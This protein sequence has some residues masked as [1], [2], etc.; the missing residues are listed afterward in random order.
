MPLR[1][2]P[3]PHSRPQDYAHVLDE[4]RAPI[5]IAHADLW[6][7]L[8]PVL[9]QR[10]HLKRVIQCGEIRGGHL[11]WEELL[12]RESP[13]LEASPTQS[14]DVAFW[15]W[16]SGS[17]GAAKAAVHRHQ[18]WG[19]CCERYAR[20]IL[21]IGPLDR[22]FSSS[23]LFHAY[24]LGHGLAFPFYV[25]AATV[26]FPGR[27]LPDSILQT[28]HETPPSL[29]FSVPTLFA[30]M[31]QETDQANPFDLSSVR[32]AI[33]AA[34]PLPAAI[35]QRWQNRFGMELLDG[36][37]STEVLHIYISSRAGEVRA[38]STGKSIPGYQVRITDEDGDEAP[39]GEIGD[40]WVKGESTAVCYWQRSELSQERMQGDWFFTGDKYRRDQDGYFWYAGRSDDM[41]RVSGHW[42]S[43]IEIEN[44][45]IEHPAVLES[46]VVPDP[47]G[48]DLIK[49]RA[50]AVLN[51]G[52]KADEDL[53]RELQNFVKQRLSAYK[54]PRRVDFVRDL[55][56]TAAGKIQ[57]FKLRNHS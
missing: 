2:P 39:P 48:N 1:F 12:A 52:S 13:E 9:K 22:T 27:P 3:T 49:P 55:P 26:L 7:N 16:T 34:E 33:S 54:Y 28:V 6:P 18:D 8:E 10:T 32:L 45:L 24:G 37:G 25:G 21:D 38:G 31:L 53:V 30:Q 44:T 11:G 50:F 23:K 15:L 47:D 42:V 56:K 5:L 17:T 20:T 46:A 35:Y 4:S 57:R 14:T 51:R 36:I 29:F 43:P 19:H 41:F 40:L